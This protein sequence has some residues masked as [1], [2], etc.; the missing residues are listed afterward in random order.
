[1]SDSSSGSATQGAAIDHAD[2]PFVGT[3]E[4]LIAQEVYIDVLN[5]GQGPCRALPGQTAGSGNGYVAEKDVEPHVWNHLVRLD[6]EA[7][8][9][10]EQDLQ[11]NADS[12]G[13]D[14]GITG[15]G[16]VP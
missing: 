8:L 4:P 9:R 2:L 10:Q 15:I 14:P 7:K 16:H 11:A 5:P 6:G 12:P 13:I 1:M 3:G